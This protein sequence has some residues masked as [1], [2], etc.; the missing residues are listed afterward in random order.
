MV[1]I[2]KATTRLTVVLTGN[3]KAVQMASHVADPNDWSARNSHASKS[4]FYAPTSATTIARTNT[5]GE[6]WKGLMEN[7]PLRIVA[8]T[9]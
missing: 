5:P 6:F 2:G 1:S 7:T 9:S 4:L 8:V 3:P